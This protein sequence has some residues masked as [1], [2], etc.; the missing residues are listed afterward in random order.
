MSSD[1]QPTKPVVSITEMAKM[2]GLSYQRF[3]Q[4]RRKGYFP[5]PLQD[6]DT[7]RKFYD[8]ELQKTCLLVRQRNMGINGKTIMFYSARRSGTAPLLRL[9]C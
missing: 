7:N 9:A 5:E 4:L 1:V 2:C 8:E 6:A 3:A